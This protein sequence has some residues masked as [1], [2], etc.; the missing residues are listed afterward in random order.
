MIRPVSKR[1]CIVFRPRVLLIQFKKSTQQILDK[2]N[3]EAEIKL[4]SYSDLE[5]NS[6]LFDGDHEPT[7]SAKMPH[8]FD[9]V[10][11]IFLK[12]EILN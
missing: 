3:K 10:D 5:I 8:V 7:S 6:T 2:D 1:V 9:F 11:I 12:N 4:T